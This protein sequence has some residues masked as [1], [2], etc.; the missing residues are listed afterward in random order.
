MPLCS[1]LLNAEYFSDQVHQISTANA[2][3]LQALSD[4]V[5]SEIGMINSYLQ[6]QLA[7]IGP[8]E[9]LLTIPT[10]LSE[11][12]TWFPKFINGFLGPYYSA[13]AKLTA[14]VI[15][16]ESQVTSLEAAVI[17]A[18]ERLGITVTI[19]SSG[20]FCTII[21]PTSGMLEAAE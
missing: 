3:Q 8:I 11:I 7:L 19:A 18:A 6:D 9:A 12:L 14:Q 17:S 16:L 13:Y 10:D 1:A 15:A 20:A 5:F 4:K 2:E 21:A